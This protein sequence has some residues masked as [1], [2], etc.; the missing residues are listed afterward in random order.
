M[1]F[2]EKGLSCPICYNVFEDATLLEAHATRYHPDGENTSPRYRNSPYSL[3]NYE[4]RWVC[5]FGCNCIFAEPRDLKV[6]MVNSHEANELK[7]WGYNT[8]YLIYEFQ[9][10]HLFIEKFGGFNG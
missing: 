4:N 10:S 8:Q 6:H 5:V 2:N 9:K 3:V 1:L 7:N